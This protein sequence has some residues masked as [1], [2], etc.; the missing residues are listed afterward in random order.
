MQRIIAVLIFLGLSIVSCAQEYDVIGI[1]KGRVVSGDDFA[2][3]PNAHIKIL[4]NKTGAV[5][6][7][8]GEFKIRATVSDSLKITCIGYKPYRVLVSPENL[9]LNKWLYIVLIP[10]VKILSEVQIHPWPATINGLKQAIVETKVEKSKQVQNA[11][12]NVVIAAYMGRYGGMS[13]VGMNDYDNY[14]NTINGPQ[15]FNIR[16]AIE[17][18]HGILSDGTLPGSYK[19]FKLKTKDNL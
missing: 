18:L 19:H 6:D 15:N 16:G 11:E 3:I 7:L 10:D 13:K 8:N 1:V 17:L 2:I 5:A 12:K 14:L 4:R 9:L